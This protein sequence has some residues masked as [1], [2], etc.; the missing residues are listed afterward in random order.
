MTINSVLNE[1]L[2]QIS[3]SKKEEAMLKKTADIFCKKIPNS[4]LGGSLAKGTMIKKRMQDVDIFVVFDNEEG[5]RKL[6]EILRKKNLKLKKLHG[7]RDYFQIKSSD[8][9]VEIVPVVKVKKA[10]DVQNVTDFSLSHVSYVRRKL[11]K[12][13][14]LHDEIKLAKVFCYAND[15][16]GAESYISGFSGYA[17]ELLIIYFGSFVKFLRGIQKKKFVDIE[18]NFK[19]EWET[20]NEINTSKLQSPLV[21]VDPT[22]KYRNVCAGLSEE[23]FSRFLSSA[24]G[25]LKKPSYD[26]FEKKDFDVERF[27]KKKGKFIELKFETNRQGGDIAGTKMK[28][29]FKFLIK[30]LERKKQKV[31]ASEFVYFGEGSEAKAF[32]RVREKKV[33]DVRGP[34]LS[35]K[36][37]VGAFKKV[38]RKIYKK[39]GFAWAKEKIDIENVFKKSMMIAGEMGISN[40]LWIA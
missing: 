15:C 32:L 37:A 7:S 4:T 16:Y 24:K 13:K 3:V 20:R 39:A 11:Q 25:F 29:F 18:K 12:N 1:V 33:I 2:E 30:E 36:K 6:E 28:K 14:K 26:F 27:K 22:Y 17:L 5:T 8:V 21:V 34:S 35:D 38:R 23:T 19:N 31:A 9:L 10:E 40:F